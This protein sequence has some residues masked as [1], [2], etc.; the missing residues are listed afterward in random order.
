[1]RDLAA[2]LLFFRDVEKLLR[3]DEAPYD[4]SH[5]EPGPNLYQELCP[6]IPLVAATRTLRPVSMARSRA[7][8]NC[9]SG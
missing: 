7:M 6:L 3:L 9:C 2:V 8:A 4:A 5:E 1:M